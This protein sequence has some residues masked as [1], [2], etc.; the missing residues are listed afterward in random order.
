MKKIYDLYFKEGELDLIKHVCPEY[1]VDNDFLGDDLDL[2]FVKRFLQNQLHQLLNSFL[3]GG[4][5]KK[6]FVFYP[7]VKDVSV[8]NKVKIKRL[9][10]VIKILNDNGFDFSKSL[11]YFNGEINSKRISILL[12]MLYSD[13]SNVRFSG[14][15]TLKKEKCDVVESKKPIKELKNYSKKHL[16]KYLSGY[17]LHG[18]YATNDYVKG[19]SD[20]DTF[21][22][23]SN[24]TLQNPIKLEELRDKLYAVRK[25]YLEI[26]PLQHHGSMLITE[27]DVDK[28]CQSYF[29]VEIFEYSKSFFDDK[30]RYFKLRDYRSENL[31]NMFWWVSHFRG[32]VLN[33]SF[34]L[35]SYDSKFL[36]HGLTL[37]PSHYLQAKN[38]VKYKKYSFDC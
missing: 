2:E 8:E 15:K 30:D 27:Y 34:R 16:S 1:Y 3:N 17:Y 9:K 24:K 6:G 37:F 26:D 28:Y 20:L 14:M 25:Y 36:Y 31:Y 35:N 7:F 12:S 38:I 19:W 11:E 4:Y 10:N 5:S 32:L 21:G 13:F 18:S 22:I 29:P 33:K 23:V